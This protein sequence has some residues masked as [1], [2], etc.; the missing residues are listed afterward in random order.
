MEHNCSC[1]L[2]AF[3]TVFSHLQAYEYSAGIWFVARRV[4]SLNGLYAAIYA[5]G[6]GFRFICGVVIP[7]TAST[8]GFLTILI[9]V[10]SNVWCWSWYLTQQCIIEQLA[11]VCPNLW[12][13][14]HCVQSWIFLIFRKLILWFKKYLILLSCLTS[15]WL[16]R[17][18][19]RSSFRPLAV[20]SL[21]LNSLHF[22]ISTFSK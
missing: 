20:E 4:Y 21:V 16:E 1:L 14:W 11:E 8:M 22:M 18:R 10:H 19:N 5:G 17:D 13:L 3:E 7:V 6:D 9:L 2:L 15:E 12:H